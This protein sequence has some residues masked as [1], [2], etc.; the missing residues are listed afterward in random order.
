[1]NNN[2]IKC[3]DAETIAKL[4]RLGFS[5]VSE[6]NGITTF[7][8]DKSIPVNFSAGDKIVYTNKID[9]GG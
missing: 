8:N 3:S 7:V 1:M 4:K 9:C 5:I 6:S 2:F